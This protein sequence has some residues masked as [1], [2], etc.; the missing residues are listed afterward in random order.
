MRIP[1][2][3]RLLLGLLPRELRDRFGADIG[4][5]FADRL[6]NARSVPERARIWVQG[7][8]DILVHSF[9]ERV[10]R[11]DPGRGHG[12]DG[13]WIEAQNLRWALRSLLRSR[14]LSS[15]AVLT[16]TLGIGA[17]TATFSVLDT[18]LLEGMPYPDP[19][20]LVVLWPETTFNTAMVADVLGAVPALESATGVSGWNLTLTGV[21]EP[22]EVAANRVSPSHFRVL[23]VSPVLGRGFEPEDGLPGAP[24]VVI[25]SHRFW[26]R[27]FG[28]DPRV[29]GRALSMA[30]AGTDGRTVIGIMPR[31]FRPPF[32][33]PAVWVPLTHAPSVS[34]DQDPTWYVNRCIARLVPGATVGQARAQLH[35]YALGLQ[36][37]LPLLT[38]EQVAG[39]TV[40]PLRAFVTRAVGPVLWVTLGAVSLVLLIASVN[41]ANLILARG[42]SRKRD[43]AVRAALGAGRGRVTRLLLAE[44]ALLNVIGGG[45]GIGLSS[46][47]VRAVVALAPPGFPRVD[48]VGVNGVALLFA[49]GITVLATV[50]SG[51]VPA[52]RLGRVDA[53]AALG[54]SGRGT[55][56]GRPPHLSVA[57]VGVEMAL[58]VMVAVGST[59]MLRSLERL[60]AVDTGVDGKD[61]LVLRT[62]PP[63]SRYADPTAA[64]EYNREVLE[65]V[66]ALPGIESVAGIDLLPGTGATSTYPTWPEGL[67]AEGDAE[68]PFVNFRVVTP[69][70]FETVG[71]DLLLGRA[72]SPT[73][74][75]TSERV[76]VVNQ[77][78]VDRFWPAGEPLGRAV[79]TLRAD[80]A[81]YRV[82]GV[83]GNVRQAGLADAPA[84]EMYVT[85]AQWGEGR[86]L[87][88]LA[89]VGAG[90]P[91]EHAPAVRDAIWSVDAEVPISGVGDLESVYD[92]SAA[93]TRFLT[94]VLTSFGGVAMLLGAIGVFGVT[95]FTVGR[96]LPEFGVR[97][98]LGSTRGEVLRTALGTCLL[99]VGAGLGAGLAV[100]LVS[101]VALRS[102]L[103]EVEPR[104]P[105]T[106][107]VT[108]A[109][110]FTV[111]L[112]AALLPA[113]RGSRVD[114]VTVLNGE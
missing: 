3:Y 11:A 52:I 46:G 67:D 10:P 109:T 81:R 104:D 14:L 70:Y 31:D 27:A 68:V 56:S 86:R 112:V 102:V 36:N 42:E 29:I 88:V 108:A 66:A 65:R 41:V 58:A 95:G 103:F 84:P 23:G 22:V 35:S 48:E 76:M 9:L 24:G 69:G 47:L 53:T 44:A 43:L 106:F 64:L 97:I 38:D 114:P 13:R 33:S 63:R 90:P 61:V 89:R 80:G 111:A 98:A 50:A 12:G 20:R 54:R 16:L 17:T 92:R 55:A 59:L 79:R 34:A 15:I 7:V 72:L 19:E 75:P 83:V 99:P 93:T 25:L 100:S 30:G 60:T 87:W 18:I 85:Q 51:L 91:L 49:L 94:L 5:T 32:G 4:A 82:V 105:A 28:G 101:S 39:A 2:I 73:D 1:R 74:D 57:L 40:R 8:A 45:L 113:W 37:R 107:V 26:M 77:A 110:L 96:R 21:G 78:F 6:R 71:T 62:A